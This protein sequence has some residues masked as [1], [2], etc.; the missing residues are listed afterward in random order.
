MDEVA[1]LSS[2]L[3]AFFVPLI[4]IIV[5]LFLAKGSLYV[6]KQ[7]TNYIIERFG[8]FHKVSL[9]GLRIKIPIVDRIAKKVPLRI[10]QLDSVVETK[11][12]D[13]VFVT[14]PVS[15]QY[16]V[17]NVADSYYRLA[18]PERQIQSY[19]YDRVRT[20]LA[21]LDLDDA[22]SS[23][24][25]I[26]QDVETTLSTAMKT[27]GFAIINTLVTD[28]NPDP[29]V[30]ASMNSINAAQR[31]R[32]A[33]ISLAEAEKIKIVKQAE[34]DA[35]YKR[36]QGEGIA[37]QRKAIVDG[38]VEQYESLRDAGIGNEAQEML[39]LTQYFDTLQEVAKASNTQTLMLPSN[40][41]GV[42]DAMTELR[43]SLFVSAKAGQQGSSA[44]VAR[45]PE[46]RSE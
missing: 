42:S 21:K 24:D 29:T 13:N 11:T 12:K 25:Q 16:Q 36:L 40:P 35:E 20:S 8:K 45:K 3:T 44:P 9:P 7:Q 34:A 46:A 43:N 22:F 30:R 38:L 17:Q 15:V 32:E 6:V 1:E 10:M 37:Q 27:Y 18:D 14:I 23:K 19:V 28:I 31:E 2:L 4:V 26:A 41:G 39:L 5:L 33:A